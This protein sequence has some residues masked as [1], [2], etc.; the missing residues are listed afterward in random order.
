MAR[1]EIPLGYLYD[2]VGHGGPFYLEEVTDVPDK[3][4]FLQIVDEIVA[5]HDKK[6]QD[7][8]SDGD[9]LA[10]VRASEH[11]GIPAWVGCMVR[12]NDKMKRLQTFAQKGELV[13]ESVEDSLLDLAVYS[14]IGLVLFREKQ[15]K[16]VTVIDEG[17]LTNHVHN[18]GS[19]GWR[20]NASGDQQFRE[21]ISLICPFVDWRWT[22]RDPLQTQP[23]DW[24]AL[25][26]GWAT[27]Q[28][29]TKETP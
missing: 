28:P 27:G 3:T 24:H 10:N 29:L 12:A 14:I 19:G 6:Q 2:D 16:S 17:T 7:Y 22:P 23:Q 5:M 1:R 11:F 8:G 18:Y 9:P 15:I 4:P 13:N 21:C 26:H 25:E 20:T